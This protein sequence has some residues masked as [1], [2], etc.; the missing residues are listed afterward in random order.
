M[1]RFPASWTLKSGCFLL[2]IDSKPKRVFNATFRKTAAP[3]MNFAKNQKSTVTVISHLDFYGS[4]TEMFDDEFTTPT[5]RQ[6]GTPCKRYRNKFTKSPKKSAGDAELKP[7]TLPWPINSALAVAVQV[8]KL[9]HN[10]CSNRRSGGFFWLL[11]SAAGKLQ[12]TL[13][14]L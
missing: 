3:C 7:Q 10:R 4:G 9:K 14:F 11:F 6:R 12:S 2:V 1:T 8:Q 13:E 5:P